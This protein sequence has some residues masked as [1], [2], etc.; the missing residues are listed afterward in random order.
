MKQKNSM[1][2]GKECAFVLLQINKAV[3]INLRNYT[4]YGMAVKLLATL[5]TFLLQIYQ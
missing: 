4:I 2:K 1:W 3:K 5:Y